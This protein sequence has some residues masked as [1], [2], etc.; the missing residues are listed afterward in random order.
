MCLIIGA[1][2]ILLGADTGFMKGGRQCILARS[3]DQ[4]VQSTEKNFRLHFSLLRMGSRGTFV[5]CTAKFRESM[6]QREV[7]VLP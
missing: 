6:L 3:V 5:L 7:L 2:T 1:A 4:S